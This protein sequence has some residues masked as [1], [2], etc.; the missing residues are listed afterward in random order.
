MAFSSLAGRLLIW[1]LLPRESVHFEWA[2][3]SDIV[4]YGFYL[5]SDIFGLEL[6]PSHS[7]F[8]EA[9]GECLILR[10][11]KTAVL[12]AAERDQEIAWKLLSATNAELSRFR[13]HGLL[14]VKTA[15]ERIAGFLLEAERIASNGSLELPM[16][17]QDIAGAVAT[18]ST[19]TASL[20]LSDRRTSSD[21]P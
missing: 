9:V 19:S 5:P 14:L 8:A 13:M 12:R 2:N 16:S 11:R 17:R 6:G 21:L 3:I 10:V 18:L 4:F 15:G 20:I 1:S 7:N